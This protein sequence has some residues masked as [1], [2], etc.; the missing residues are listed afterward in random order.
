MLDNV[1]VRYQLEGLSDALQWDL[2]SWVDE[3]ISSKLDSYLKKI[4][5]KDD[6]EVFIDITF[7]KNKKDKYDAIFN[8]QLDNKDFRYEREDF[9][10]PRD[11]VINA[12]D[13]L[14]EQLSS[15]KKQVRDRWL[16]KWI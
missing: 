12:F 10:I 11:L 16:E 3:E 2:K 5:K 6:A 7:K 15:D 13:R 1:K 4:L 14:K 8:F 9:T